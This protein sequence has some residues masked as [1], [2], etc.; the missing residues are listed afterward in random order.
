M[1]AKVNKSVNASYKEGKQRIAYLKAQ[2]LKYKAK[3]Q[4][5]QFVILDLLSAHND[6]L[7]T[8]ADINAKLALTGIVAAGQMR[9]S[10]NT[11]DVTVSWGALIP[12]IDNV[13]SDLV[14]VNN[15]LTNSS[16]VMTTTAADWA[17]IPSSSLS[18]AA[19]SINA[20]LAAIE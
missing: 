1:V 2:L 5:N 7:I 17:I 16:V 19:A 15:G 4:S 10:D 20:L 8:K 11:Y 9:E 18:A 6:V 13:L 12:L 3:A 14:I